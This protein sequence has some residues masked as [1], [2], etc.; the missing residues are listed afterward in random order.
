MNKKEQNL[1]FATDEEC[2]D[3][4]NNFIKKGIIKPVTNK[5]LNINNIPD[6]GVYTHKE[7][8]NDD[9]YNKR[10]RNYFIILQSVLKSRIELDL[11][12]EENN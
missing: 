1:P 8:N 3:I 11:E 4:R 6:E 7:I 10:K 9:E 12:F 5:T 2:I